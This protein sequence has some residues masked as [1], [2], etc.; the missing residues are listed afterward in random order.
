[1]AKQAESKLPPSGGIGRWKAAVGV[2]VNC[3]SGSM[4]NHQEVVIRNPRKFRE[5]SGLY[6]VAK[7]HIRPD[8]FTALCR[9]GEH[10]TRPLLQLALPLRDLVNVNFKLFR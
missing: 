9:C 4:V 5:K 2:R 6:S 8:R 3:R 7:G 10:V 1:M